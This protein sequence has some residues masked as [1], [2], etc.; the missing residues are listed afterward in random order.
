[1]SNNVYVHH[2]VHIVVDNNHDNRVYLKSLGFT[3]RVYADEQTHK[4]LINVSIKMA[5]E[6]GMCGIYREYP[7]SCI[8]ELMLLNYEAKVAYLEHYYD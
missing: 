7:I 8:P 3:V 4:L 6:T 5:Y 1:M 2:S